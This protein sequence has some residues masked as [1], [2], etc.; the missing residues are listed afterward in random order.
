MAIYSF[1]IYLKNSRLYI[2]YIH[3]IYIYT[4]IQ[5]SISDKSITSLEN[6]SL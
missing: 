6:I 2:T 3:N 4:N 5:I 1:I